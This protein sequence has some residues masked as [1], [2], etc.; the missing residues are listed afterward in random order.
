MELNRRLCFEESLDDISA[1]FIN[2]PVEQIT[3]CPEMDIFQGAA[4]VRYPWQTGP[5]A[6]TIGRHQQA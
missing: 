6:G 4:T 2:L 3:H 5:I 1:R